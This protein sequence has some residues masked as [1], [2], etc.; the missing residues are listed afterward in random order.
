MQC[1]KLSECLECTMLSMQQCTILLYYSS[2]SIRVGHSPDVGLHSVVIYCYNC[3]EGTHLTR[4]EDRQ[5][6]PMVS[7]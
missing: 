5:I 2:H 1:S 4:H 6:F 3:A 7:V